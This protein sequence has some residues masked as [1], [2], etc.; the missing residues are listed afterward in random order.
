MQGFDAGG[1]V[2]V[3]RVDELA[4]LYRLTDQLYR[5]RSLT[6]VYN[7]A[8]DVI[9]G[10]LG[11]SRASVLLFDEAGVMQFVG[12]RG[13]TDDYRKAVT[14][15]SPWKP[16][17]SDPEPIFVGD[18]DDTNEPDWL[19]ERIKAENIRALAFIPLVAQD[20][21]I[22]KFMTYYEQPRTFAAHEIDLAVT[23][24]RQLGFAVER[25]RA[26]LARKRA[27]EELRESEQRFRLMSEHAPVMIWMS[28]PDG[29]C[30]HLNR[31]LRSFWKVE[32][33]DLETFD[34]QGTIHPEDAPE[35]GRL[36]MKAIG[37]RTSASVMGR[38]LNAE[39][40]YRVLE[41]NAR[42]RFSPK[43]EFLGMIGVNVDITERE[44]L[45]AELNHRVK[46]TLAI[47]QGIA[48]QTFKDSDAS[49][50]ARRAFEGRLFALAVAHSLLTQANWVT[51]SLEELASDTLNAGAPDRARVSL[52]GPRI[53]LPPKQAVS[54]VMAL[55]ELCTNAVKYGALSNDTGR[56]ELGWN[57]SGDGLPRLKLVWTEHGGPAVSP[58]K[59]RGFGSFLLERTLAADLDGSVTTEFRP[60][61]LICSI[62]APLPGHR[63]TPL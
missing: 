58:P 24:A 62:D 13:L 21:V 2:L 36:M 37:A 53:M 23:I 27:E 12:W 31:M 6:D 35:I 9:L 19:K 28:H 39:G 41:T 45:L 22:G 4:S 50:E 56:I 63:G 18:I 33:E 52:S 30:L 32:E 49:P 15:H 29:S 34:W 20:L 44:L 46:N 38:Y 16:D 57:R 42:P 10:T 43:G 26:D 40:V 17:T 59:R 3:H 25:A 54:I 11:C 51:A 60:E 61:G 1:E 47:V 14:G 55:H 5:A 8:L 48:H 7:A